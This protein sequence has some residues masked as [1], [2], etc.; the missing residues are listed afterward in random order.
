MSE[1]SIPPHNSG[2]PCLGVGRT[3]TDMSRGENV[4]DCAHE[5][6]R[7]QETLGPGR[8]FKLAEWALKWGDAI[9]Q[10]FS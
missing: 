3:L 1:N 7:A 4:K 8:P 10:K 6:H 2:R 9:I 5:L